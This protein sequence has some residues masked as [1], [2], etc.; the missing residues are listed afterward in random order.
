MAEGTSEK[1]IPNRITSTS[2]TNQLSRNGKENVKWMH[3]SMIAPIIMMVAPFP[4]RSY[5]LPK[6]GVS[7]IVPNGRI[8]G[9]IPE[10][11][12]SIPY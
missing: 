8:E 6:N 10:R 12:G 9:M 3:T 11:V 7:R 5:R 4:F 1:A 2:A